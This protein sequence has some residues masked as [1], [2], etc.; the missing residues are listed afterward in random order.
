MAKYVL[1]YF[2]ARGRAEPARMIF[3]V[4]GIPFEDRRIKQ[5]DWSVFKSQT[6]AGSLPILEKDGQ[7]ITQSLVI[8]RHLA[9]SFGLDGE[10]ILDKARVEEIL[11]Y[12]IEV[13]TAWSEIAFG[14]QDE[15]S[16]EKIK[17]NYKLALDKK[18]TQIER[19]MSY[20]ESPEG[21]AVGKRMSFADI[22]LFEAFE[23]IVAQSPSALDNFPKIKSCRQKLEANKNLKIYLSKRKH[24]RF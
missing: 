2:D 1:T 18:C 8:Y 9:R 16:Q 10:T 20:S 4:A 17:E 3:A 5:E 23:E 12:L 13:K 21:W 14:P 24:T 6:P 22:M 11:E 19:I 7:T 15:E